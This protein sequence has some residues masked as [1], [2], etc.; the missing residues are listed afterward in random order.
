MMAKKGEREAAE[1]IQDH[2]KNRI[3]S[4][5]KNRTQGGQIQCQIVMFQKQRTRKEINLTTNA[6]RPTKYTAQAGM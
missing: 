3:R 4:Q 5:E 1:E 6:Y 2:N